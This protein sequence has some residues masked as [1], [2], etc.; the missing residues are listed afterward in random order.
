M[1]NKIIVILALLVA[2]VL[3][4][5]GILDS[6]S[7]TVYDSPKDMSESVLTCIYGWKDISM[8]M[9]LTPYKKGTDIYSE[10]YSTVNSLM[11]NTGHEDE[12]VS[13]GEINLKSTDRKLYNECIDTLSKNG[14]TDIS[15]IKGFTYEVNN[16][17][18]I[19]IYVA[20]IEKKWYAINIEY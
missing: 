16:T 14:I 17:E 1:K 9:P 15:S 18:E 8:F 19:T 4:A 10:A 13:K 3:C 11:K 5:V 20:K 2:I 12:Y 6:R 7:Q